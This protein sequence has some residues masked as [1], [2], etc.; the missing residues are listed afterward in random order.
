MLMKFTAGVVS[1]GVFVSVGI[2][3]QP[4]PNQPPNCATKAAEATATCLASVRGILS[5]SP[6]DKALGVVAAPE[7][8]RQAYNAAS[9][10]AAQQQAPRPN[11]RR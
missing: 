6:V 4:T 2:A 7:C 8:L 11:P 1:L 5:P 3:D 9:C 10:Y